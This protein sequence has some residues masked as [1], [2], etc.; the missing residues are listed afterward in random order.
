MTCVGLSATSERSMTSVSSG[1]YTP[2]ITKS[3]KYL[4]FCPFSRE[5][6]TTLVLSLPFLRVQKDSRDLHTI[7]EQSALFSDAEI[8]LKLSW[9]VTMRCVVLVRKNRSK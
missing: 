6:Y 8:M 4:Q 9:D 2:D 5:F 1:I 7:V 3:L